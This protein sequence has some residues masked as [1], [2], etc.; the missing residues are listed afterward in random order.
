MKKKNI[1]MNYVIMIFLSLFILSSFIYRLAKYRHD[2]PESSKS[3]WPNNVHGRK[4]AREDPGEISPESSGSL[5]KAGNI[6][7]F[8]FKNIMTCIP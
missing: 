6:S 2:L 1:R 8:Q 5:M 7:I 3:E 4:S